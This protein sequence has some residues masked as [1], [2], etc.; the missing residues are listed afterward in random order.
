MTGIYRFLNIKTN[1]SYIGQSIDIEK[2]LKEHKRRAFQ[3]GKEYYKKL[4][5]AIREYG[6]ENFYFEIVEICEKEFIYK[7]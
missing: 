7:H 3:K 1:L 5:K 2:R 4:Y 6:L